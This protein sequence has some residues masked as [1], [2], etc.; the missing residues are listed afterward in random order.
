MI[1]G[2]GFSANAKLPTTSEITDAF[3][4][5][6]NATN[7]TPAGIQA[8]IS[9]ILREFWR[10]V[11]AYTGGTA[12]SFEDHFTLLDLAANAGHNL[13]KK[14]SPAKLRAIRRLSLHRVFEILD[15]RYRENDSIRQLVNQLAEG[16]NNAIVS[17]NWDIVVE[18][19]LQQQP[20]TY[21]LRMGLIPKQGKLASMKGM[22]LLKLHGSANWA[23]C[24]S[25]RRL[26]TYEATD[27]KGALHS[28][29]LL[30]ARDF[31]TLGRSSDEIDRHF[32]SER[33]RPSCRSCNAPLSARVA[34]FSYGKAMGYFQ[35]QAVWDHA[36]WELRRAKTWMFIGYSLPDADFQLRHL[37][38]TAQLARKKAPKIVVVLRPESGAKRNYERFF[39][40]QLIVQEMT[41]P[42]DL[43]NLI[44][45]GT[46]LR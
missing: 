1:V 22:P 14:Y 34:T 35:F 41:R 29:V 3:V 24:D 6:Q 18:K 26:F 23:Y 36:L 40:D 13:G 12:P 4:S 43:V 9:E 38:K 8:E 31:A 30:E 25:C 15:S 27:G 7:V 45:D 39:G 44:A 20:Y 2:A 17:T 21:K 33:E 19:H 28:W 11:F 46:N 16:R 42:E 32:N 5:M 37:L 10:D